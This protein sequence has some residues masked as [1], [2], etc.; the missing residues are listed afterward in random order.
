MFG[1]ALANT[2]SSPTVRKL[3][4]L[5]LMALAQ[6]RRA[7]EQLELALEED[8]LDFYFRLI[9]ALAFLMDGDT[10]TAISECRRVLEFDEHT[11]MANLGLLFGYLELGDMEEAERAAEAAHLAG[12]FHW[13]VRGSL[14]GLLKR[15]GETSRASAILQSI[16][17]GAAYG[18]PAGLLCYYL[19]ANELD[20]AAEWAKKSIE[21]RQPSILL[22][23]R[24]P[25]AQ[26]LRR[27]SHWPALA[28]LMNLPDG[29]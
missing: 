6:P 5:Y 7:I 14:A 22:Y 25:I 26:E 18:A 23:M 9:L 27:S 24:L 21:Q 13:V 11:S 10:A 15:R 16:G 8:P 17:D 1:L 2:P 28:K 20:Q 12:A 19:I 29:A 4:S 3:Y